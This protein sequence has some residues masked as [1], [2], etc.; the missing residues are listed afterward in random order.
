MARR[1]G[2]TA[3][4]FNAKDVSAQYGFTV[5]M[6]EKF[7][8]VKVFVDYLFGKKPKFLGEKVIIPA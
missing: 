1:E 8:R 6:R 4:A 7:A 3:I 5:Q 2:I